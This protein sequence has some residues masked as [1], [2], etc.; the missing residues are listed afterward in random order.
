LSGLHNTTS[1]AITLH[2]SNC[3]NQLCILKILQMSA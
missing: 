1:I 2:N 3:F